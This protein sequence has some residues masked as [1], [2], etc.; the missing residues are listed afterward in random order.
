MH[1][2]ILVDKLEN[3]R[4]CTIAPLKGRVDFLFRYFS[5]NKPVAPF[6]ADCLLHIDGDCLSEIPRG[7]LGSLALID[8]T[9]RKVPGVLQKLEAPL[10]KLVRIPEHFRTAYPRMNKAG[11]DPTGGLATIEAL[12]IAAAFMGVWDISLLAHYHFKNQFLELN[13]TLWEKYALKG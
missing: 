9:W 2:E 7:S 3:P 5:G 4:K 11:L 10:P 1:Y 6:Q 12:F 8:C 13:E